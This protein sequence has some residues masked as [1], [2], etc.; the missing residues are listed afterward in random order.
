MKSRWMIGFMFFCL[1]NVFA[2]EN[3]LFGIPSA[4]IYYQHTGSGYGTSVLYFDDFGAKR[5]ICTSIHNDSLTGEVVNRH[6]ELFIDGHRVQSGQEVDRFSDTISE[7]HLANSLISSAYNSRMLAGLGYAEAGI[8]EILKKNC[9]N[10]TNQV[11]TIC[12]W[13]NLVLKS[14]MHLS[15]VSMKVE[16]VRI[17]LGSPP[18]SAFQVK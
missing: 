3:I 11:D 5:F 15:V 1:A 8:I 17:I 12:L 9:T 16:A 14:T 6:C 7:N 18:D 10:Y 4:T 2:Q 13:K